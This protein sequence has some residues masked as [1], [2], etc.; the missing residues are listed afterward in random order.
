MTPDEALLRRAGSMDPVER[1]AAGQQLALFAG[2]AEA[3]AALVALLTDARND[4]VV[5]GVATALLER[6]DAAGNHSG[7]W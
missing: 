4:S 3:D 6:P 2:S 1:V 5:V 7:L